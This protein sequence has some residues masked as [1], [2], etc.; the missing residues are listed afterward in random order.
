MSKPQAISFVRN[1][2]IKLFL[3]EHFPQAKKKA[4]SKRLSQ[5]SKVVFILMQ[6]LTSITCHELLAK[7][8]CMTYYIF[9]PGLLRFS[10]KIQ[11]YNY[12]LTKQAVDEL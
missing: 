12:L 4:G 6:P 9:F 5:K 2:L 8:C 7:I 10:W 3:G 11:A 1:G